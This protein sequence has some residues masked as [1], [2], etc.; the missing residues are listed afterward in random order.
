MGRCILT[1]QT[2]PAPR[3]SA[4]YSTTRWL[5]LRRQLAVHGTRATSRRPSSG[6]LTLSSRT[7]GWLKGTPLKVLVAFVKA[8]RSV[9]IGLAH[10]GR[11]NIAVLPARTMQMR[12]TRWWSMANSV[13]NGLTN[14]PSR[15]GGQ[16]PPFRG[17]LTACHPH[18]DIHQCTTNS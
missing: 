12:R 4:R 15:G 17:A 8:S 13:V 18:Q 5:L 14:H 10:R 3:T 9:S 2:S 6:R 1:V 16:L 11:R 7:I